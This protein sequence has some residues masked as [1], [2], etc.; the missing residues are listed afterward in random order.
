[1]PVAEAVR[2]AQSKSVD[3]RRA[4]ADA[5]SLARLERIERGGELDLR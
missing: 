5:N 4:A 2:K 1:M 3:L